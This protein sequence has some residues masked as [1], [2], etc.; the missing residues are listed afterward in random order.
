MK[1]GENI[2]KYRKEKGLTQEEMAGFLGVTAPAVNKWERGV[3]LPDITMVAPIARLL[4]VTTDTLLSCREEL[5]DLEIGQ[6]LE[7]VS[8]KMQEG[9][10]DAAF[11]WAMK[12]TQEY[13]DCEKLTMQL[14]PILDSY[15]AILAVPDPE[16]Y[17]DRIWQMYQ[18]LLKSADS[19]IVQQ[20][21]SSCFYFCLNRGEYEKAEEVLSVMPEKSLEWKQG[22]ARLCE[23]K[24]D[25][26]TAYRL[27][28]ELA[29]AGYLQING[30]FNGIYGIAEKDGDIAR[31]RFITEKQEQLAK[32]MEIGKYHEVYLKFE[33]AMERKDREEALQVLEGMVQDVPDMQTF[34]RSKLYEHMAFSDAKM[35]S[36]V[37]MLR[38]M[39][40][41]EKETDFLREDPRF[42]EILK[43]LEQAGK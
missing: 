20:A 14:C 2:R 42:Q 5:T 15:R 22:K 36:L 33:P 4:G 19:A 40:E 11:S 43:E 23:K 13:P 38:K 32:V 28:E 21:A 39:L 24:G 30:A 35:D 27:E 6:I 8:E 26:E 34:R 16:R 3:S 37:F 1:I 41:N 10:Y 9:D 12:K 29:F 18:R 25:F 7:T 17:T 31:Q